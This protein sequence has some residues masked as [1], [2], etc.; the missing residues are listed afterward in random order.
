M[1]LYASFSCKISKFRLGIL[2]VILVLM[3]VVEGSAQE[4]L[5]N[6]KP[7]FL[8]HGKTLSERKESLRAGELSRYQ[9]AFRKF[10]SVGSC[11]EQDSG[12]TELE[13]RRFS[14]SRM[15][16]KEQVNWCL[17]LIA[18]ELQSVGKLTEWFIRNDLNLMKLK[19]D[20]RSMRHYKHN[21]SGF[22]FSVTHGLK[23]PNSPLGW[24]SRL[25]A[26]GLS[27]SVVTTTD[28]VPLSVGSTLLIL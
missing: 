3:A 2:A 17:F 22:S 19:Q 5:S 26:Y 24:W 14:W 18:S 4:I 7:P 25:I 1:N 16:T 28:G 9:D 12:N 15:L 27:I 20:Q 10:P 8:W 21:D 13:N 11:V 23:G 6:E